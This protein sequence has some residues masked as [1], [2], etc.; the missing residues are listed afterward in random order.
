MR[1]LCLAADLSTEYEK[2]EARLQRCVWPLPNQRMCSAKTV[3]VLS[4]RAETTSLVVHPQGSMP[5]VQ[6]AFTRTYQACCGCA[7]VLKGRLDGL[8]QPACALPLMD[9]LLLGHAGRQI[10]VLQFLCG[11]RGPSD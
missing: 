5:T 3:S 2:E 6:Q 1:H 8:L 9:E 10:S 4:R 11:T 7:R